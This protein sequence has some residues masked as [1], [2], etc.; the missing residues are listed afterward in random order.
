MPDG[1]DLDEIQQ[2]VEDI[3][4]NQSHSVQDIALLGPDILMHCISGICIPRTVC[5]DDAFDARAGATTMH[6]C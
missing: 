6:L 1:T 2:Y 4:T 5:W 3:L